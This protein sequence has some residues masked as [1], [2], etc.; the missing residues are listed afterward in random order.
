SLD[1][2]PLYQIR[3]VAVPLQIAPGATGTHT[4]KLWVGPKTATKLQSLAPGL[5]R[6]VDYSSYTIL[7][8]LAEGL[9]WVLSH[10]YA[11]IGNGGWSIIAIVV[12]RKLILY[13]LSAKQFQSMAKMRSVQPR[14]EALTERSGADKQQLN[15]AMMELYK[16]EK[17]NPAGGCLPL[18]I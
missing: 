13:P 16:K 7:A 3:S 14:L 12:L 18:L 4:A 5:D 15:I 6:A 10:L 8:V 17:I 1:G 11:L 9:F 2:V